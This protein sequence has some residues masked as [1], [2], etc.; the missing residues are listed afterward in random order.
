[1]A[2]RLSDLAGRSAPT[3]LTPHPGEMG[4]LLD[5]PTA[6]V[7]A[8]RLAAARRAAELAR[9]VVV[10]KGHRT[11]IADPE[12][13]TA[14]SADTWCRAIRY[15]LLAEMFGE[16]IARSSLSMRKYRIWARRN[17]KSRSGPRTDGM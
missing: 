11:L 12:G 7:Q 8:D 2:G 15:A 17:R 13:Y 9:A 6:E 4:R 10:L 1:M 14:A 16:V 5:V 3:V